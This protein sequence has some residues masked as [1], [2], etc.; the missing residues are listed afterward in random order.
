M[1]AV[2]SNRPAGFIPVFTPLVA[3][4]RKVSRLACAFGDFKLR[5]ASRQRVFTL[6]RRKN[7]AEAAE[8]T[9]TPDPM[10]EVTEKKAPVTT[11]KKGTPVSP[12]MLLKITSEM[13]GAPI[14]KVAHACGYYS[15]FTTTATGE[16]EVRVA[17]SDTFAYMQALLA[18]QGTKLAPPIRS[19]RRSNRQP[20]I[21]IGKTG[22]IVVGGRY[23]TIAGF[24]FGAEL[25][26]RVRIEA[27][28]GKITIFAADPD[29]YVSSE[30]LDLDF[31]ETD[32]D[33]ELDL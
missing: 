33:S 5:W 27:E 23:T 25:D 16:V 24:P 32:E 19:N 6:P 15:E 9:V 7:T 26:S 22:N 11:S 10:P 20:I 30:E 14:D 28:K 18:A 3:S 8:P 21:K 2:S 4:L 12:E 13:E 29:E 17:T 1:V 31:D